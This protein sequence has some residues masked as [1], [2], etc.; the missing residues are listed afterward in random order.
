VIV[1]RAVRVEDDGSQ[2]ELGEV[3]LTETG[4]VFSHLSTLA[5]GG[6]I[7]DLRSRLD[8]TPRAYAPRERVR[9]Y[10][11]RRTPWPGGRS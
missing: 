6:V 10:G 5:G 9:A 11:D 3:R 8:D 2:T 7:A 4:A 1:L